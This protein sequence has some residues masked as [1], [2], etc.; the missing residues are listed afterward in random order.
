MHVFNSRSWES[1][2]VNL[3]EF[4]SGLTYE[5]SSRPVRTAY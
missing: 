1:E 3:Y 5:V 2:V 4:E